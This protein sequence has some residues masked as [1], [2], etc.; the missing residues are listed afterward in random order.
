MTNILKF[1]VTEDNVGGLTLWVWDEDDVIT[2]VHRYGGDVENIISDMEALRNG[3]TDIYEWDGNDITSMIQ[4][5]Y[6]EQIRDRGN[7]EHDRVIADEDDTYPDNMVLN[8]KKVF[9]IKR[10]DE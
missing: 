4:D 10:G 2:Y 3:A 5:I 6:N 9:V 7:G 1:R 8:S